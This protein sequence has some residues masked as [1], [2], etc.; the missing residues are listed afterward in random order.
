MKN[1]KVKKGSGILISCSLSML[2]STDRFEEG[3]IYTLYSD[4]F[5]LIEVGFAENESVMDTKL[6]SKARI[7]LDKKKG[8]KKELTLLINTLNELGFK[9]TKNYNFKYTSSLI[10]HICTLGWPVGGSLHKQRKIKK[11]LIHA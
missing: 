4:K 3:I 8:K 2:T 10:R 7:L 5:N 9:Y 6:S 1:K 11:G